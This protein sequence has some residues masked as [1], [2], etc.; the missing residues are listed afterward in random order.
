M[1]ARLVDYWGQRSLR[2]RRLI[3]MML[4]IAL[5]LLLWLLVARP[6]NAALVNAKER[7]AEAVARHGRILARIDAIDHG[8]S[9]GRSSTKVGS[10]D[11]FVAEAA[12]QRGLTLDSS[13]PQGSDAVS[14]RI[15]H[16]RPEAL[17]DWL[18]G[19]ERQ[20]IVIAEMHMTANADG[21]VALDAQLRRSGT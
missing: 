19:F 11:L 14:V 12:S 15:A 16:A 18:I 4:I 21:S 20:G 8:A 6:L 3:A 13:S 5:P 1:I 2:E 10:L 17:V 9:S 7:Q